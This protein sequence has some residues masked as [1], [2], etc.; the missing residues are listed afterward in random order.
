MGQGYTACER[1]SA[2]SRS[3]TP[4]QTDVAEFSDPRRLGAVII[5][6][7]A[8]RFIIGSLASSTH[9]ALSHLRESKAIDISIVQT[10]FQRHCHPS[11]F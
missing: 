7:E 10:R 1:S 8:L 3:S 6:K 11:H 2:Y 9:G 4:I 5:V